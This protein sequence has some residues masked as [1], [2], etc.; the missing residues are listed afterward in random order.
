MPN[1]T[2]RRAAPAAALPLAALAP[3]RYLPSETPCSLTAL[4]FVRAPRRRG[5]APNFWNVPA[6]T[7]IAEARALG[8]AYAEHYLQYLADAPLCIPDGSLWFVFEA[9]AAQARDKARRDDSAFVA[10]GFLGVLEYAARR[11]AQRGT[12]FQM[13][14][15]M[16][17]E[18]GRAV[19]RV[20]AGCARGCV[21]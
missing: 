2:I 7:G 1:T 13:A 21:E 20:L 18:M 17:A 6:C 10:Y 16:R 12:A 19:G 4:P 15:A 3:R 8:G 9:M 5:E 11:E 14:G